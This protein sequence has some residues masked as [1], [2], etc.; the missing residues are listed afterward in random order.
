MT[1]PDRDPTVP[2]RQLSGPGNGAAPNG[3][4]AP[5]PG[6]AS[7]AD[8]TL[9]DG[10]RGGT[11][12]GD[13]SAAAGSPYRPAPPLPPPEPF[14]PEQPDTEPAPTTARRPWSERRVTAGIVA[15]LLLACSGLFLFDVASVRTGQQAMRWRTVLA[16]ELASR[17]LD[18]L[19]VLIGAA[20][21]VL[22]G[23]WLLVLV[24]TPGLR[25]ALPQL[26]P[27]ASMRVSLDRTAAAGLLQDTALQVAGVSRADVT[28]RRRRVT[29]R[30]NVRFRE[31][32]EVRSELNEALFG[33]VDR[34]A[35]ARQ[36]KLTLKLRPVRG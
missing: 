22:L 25:R 27:S 7:A 15:V 16:D 12:P 10:G 2:D 31:M 6:G 19:W 4:D 11:V 5:E 26:P 30:A 24:C 32:D 33:R 20:V 36:P 35:L 23:L 9:P 3:R 21:A 18:D 13:G 8:A 1:D 14:T 28:L 29:V 17:P 34:L